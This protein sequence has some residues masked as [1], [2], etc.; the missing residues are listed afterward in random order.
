MK[1]EG[2]ILLVLALSLAL[3]AIVGGIGWFLWLN[4]TPEM[5][6]G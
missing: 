5:A 2:R 3:V 1:K 4:S 6:H